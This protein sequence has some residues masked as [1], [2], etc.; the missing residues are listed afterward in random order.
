MLPNG[1]VPLFLAILTLRILGF[2]VSFFPNMLSK[3]AAFFSSSSH[4][5]WQDSIFFGHQFN[6]EA[7][8]QQV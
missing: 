2:F 6:L 1:K 4:L 7:K 5:V 8:D 3:I